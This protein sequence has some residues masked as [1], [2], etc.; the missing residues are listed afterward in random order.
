M[1]NAALS[2]SNL[3]KS[4]SLFSTACRSRSSEYIHIERAGTHA[5]C[6]VIRS[7]IL[8]FVQEVHQAGVR[9]FDVAERNIVIRDGDCYGMIDFE[10]CGDSHKC[11][12]S[13]DFYERRKWPTER[14][15]LKLLN[16]CTDIFALAEDMGFWKHGTTMLFC[17][18]SP[19]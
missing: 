16:G 6:I 15:R 4:S 1:Q 8:Q 11:G 10:D 18:T 14:E 9:P 12:W 2:C 3:E 13:Y 19:H 17:S 5:S 7:K